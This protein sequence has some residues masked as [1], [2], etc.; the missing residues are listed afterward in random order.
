MFVEANTGK[1]KQN[2]GRI[3]PHSVDCTCHVLVVLPWCLYSHYYHCLRPQY[4]I[5]M[6]DLQ[7]PTGVSHLVWRSITN[8]AAV[9]PH[10][11]RIIAVQAGGQC[12]VSQVSMVLC[13]ET[14]RI[15]RAE[16]W[17]PPGGAN[18]CNDEH[19]FYVS[20]NGEIRHPQSSMRFT[21]HANAMIQDASS[22]FSPDQS[23]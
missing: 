15:P 9:T 20:K 11:R 6:A 8:H 21:L 4:V 23:A 17:G 5:W 22:T 16:R 19:H 3:L 14:M 10:L 2:V 13:I 7:S 18:A 1:Y 12:D